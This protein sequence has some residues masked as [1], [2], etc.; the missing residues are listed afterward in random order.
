MTLIFQ[1]LKTKKFST[2]RKDLGENL[3]KQPVAVRFFPSFLKP[4]GKKGHEN[5]KM[6]ILRPKK[7]GH[8]KGVEVKFS[9][10]AKR[11][12]RA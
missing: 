12:L 6:F 1:S 2:K 10:W 9:G 8:T 11:T 5:L 7:T 4:C 3:K